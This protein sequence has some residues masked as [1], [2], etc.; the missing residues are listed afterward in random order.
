MSLENDC[1]FR[2]VYNLY[3]DDSK[4]LKAG[5]IMNIVMVI[6]TVIGTFLMFTRT[7]EG[8]SL[9][10][11]GIE[12]F[13]FYTVLSNVF[14]GLVSLIYLLIVL[15]KK[16]PD[17]IRGLK[18]A[19]LVGVMITFA[20]VAF[21]FGPLYGFL[22]FYKGGNL[23]FHLLLPL[24]ALFEFIL[25]KWDWMPFRY[26]VF[27]TI[28]TVLYG[29]GY[30]LNILKNGVGGPWPDSNDFYSFLSWGWKGGIIIFTAIV[31]LAFIIAL[32]FRG[33][34]NKRARLKA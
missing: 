27:A 19:A 16:D 22:R 28:P 11:S 8:G 4:R 3:M 12:N 32:V 25:Y 30:T 34:N 5:V 7:P 29:I 1:P 21:M 20:V 14:C 33:I 15:F 26:A 18:L 6:F 13:K 9:N 2:T 31:F 10:A 17:K 24:A 23:F